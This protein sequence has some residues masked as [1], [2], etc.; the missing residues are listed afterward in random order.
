MPGALAAAMAPLLQ[1]IPA[2][3]GIIDKN[4]F[5]QFLA[6]LL[7][8]SGN[9]TRLVENVNYTTVALNENFGDHRISDADIQKYGRK[10][11]QK[12]NQQMIAN[13]IYGGEFGRKNLGNVNDGD[14]WKFRGSGFIQ[15][16]GRAAVE[17]F[18]KYYNRQNGTKY[19]IDEMPDYLRNDKVISLHGACWFFTK[20]KNILPLAEANKFEAVC[21]KINGGLIGYHERQ[22]MLSICKK[23]I[24]EA[25]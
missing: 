24:A 19:T 16:T 7:H 9:F 11:G 8:E 1:D 17:A 5:C 22:V 12:A 10:P 14:G 3:Y 4:V 13:I 15:L 6:N 2:K 25:A 23:H 18:T 20:Y 21:K